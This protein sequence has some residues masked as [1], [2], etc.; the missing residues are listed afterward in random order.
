[1][2]N[3]QARKKLLEMQRGYFVETQDD[4]TLLYAGFSK[5]TARSYIDS[6]EKY[7][8]DNKDSMEAL[9]I[10]YNSEDTVITHTM[11]VELRDRLL[12]ESSLYSAYHIWQNYKILDDEGSVDELDSKENVNALT[13]LIQIVR[14]AYK[15]NLKLTSLLNGYTQKF[16]LYCGQQQRVLSEAQKGIMKQIADYIIGDGAIT[17]AELNTVDTDLWRSAIMSFGAPVLTDEMQTLSKF[18]LRAA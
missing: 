15:K 7:L 8:E 3:L 14:Y 2:S 9:R 16:S 4:D 11:L 5:E 18:I 17:P 12:A 1:M 13:N 6:F 10:I